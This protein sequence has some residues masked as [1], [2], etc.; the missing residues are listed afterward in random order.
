MA[1]AVLRPTGSSRIAVGASCISRSCSATRKR[2]ASLHTMTGPAALAKPARRAAVSWNMVRSPVR[3]R[4]CLGR[5]SRDSGQS[6]VPEPPERMTGTSFMAGILPHRRSA[7]TWRPAADGVIGEALLFHH[8]G[9]VEVAAVENH[10]RFE[11]LL[12]VVEVRAAEF[13]PLRD[14]HE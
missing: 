10:R 3:A 13:L 11:L 9:V 2:C 8:A 6:R 12:E 5:S 14:D 7:R 4:S 1:G